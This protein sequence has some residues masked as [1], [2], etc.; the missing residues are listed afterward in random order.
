M[1]IRH[2][3]PVKER[4]AVKRG[5]QSLLHRSMTISHEAPIR[6][7]GRMGVLIQRLGAKRRFHCRAAYMRGS[8]GVA[9]SFHPMNRATVINKAPVS[10]YGEFIRQTNSAPPT[11]GPLAWP[12]LLAAF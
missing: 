5:A 3:H 6:A 12:R 11:S 1:S 2:E 10:R 7:P 9:T 8:R 4:Q